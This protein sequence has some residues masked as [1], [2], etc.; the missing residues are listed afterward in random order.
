M[1]RFASC[2]KMSFLYEWVMQQKQFSKVLIA[3][4]G[5]IALRLQAACKQL[6]MQTVAVFCQEDGAA[7]FVKQADQAFRIPGSGYSAYLNMDEIIAVATKCGAQAI[8]PGYGFLSENAVFAKKVL[9]AGLVWIGPRPELITLMGDKIAARHIAAD[10][11]VPVIPGFMIADFSDTGLQLAEKQAQAIGYPLIIKDPLGGGGKGMRK[12]HAQQDFIPM[13]LQVCQQAKRLSSATVLLVEKYLTNVRHVEVQVVGDGNHAIHLFE[14]DC[15]VQR[16]YQKIIEEAPCCFVS[17]LVLERMRNLAAH[18]AQRIKYDNVG[19]IEYA[20]TD[21]E[22]FYFLEMNTRLQVEH[23]V[24]ERVTGIDIVCLQLQ[25]A[26]KKPLP[27]I[28]KDITIRGHAIECRIYAEDPENNFIPC[29]GHLS[30]FQVPH[31]PYIRVDHDLAQGGEI[32]PFF[33]PMIAKC[34]GWALTRQ[35]TCAALQAFLDNAVIEGLKTNKEFLNNL[36]QHHLF[37]EGKLYTESLSDPVFVS[38]ILTSHLCAHAHDNDY[39][40][41]TCALV[42]ALQEKTKLKNITKQTKTNCIKRRWKEQ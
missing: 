15:S 39:I 7:L 6:G 27:F 25:L 24:T 4:R 1:L 14:R 21:D 20:V 18:L 40:H 26:Q 41:A 17:Q 10:A 2:L 34:V 9:A 42:V 16:R 13:L 23:A 35:E 5:E 32:S 36:L 19:T 8:H 30:R 33:D 11:G 3:N 37:V 38:Q 31:M 12:V 28:Q 29:A 22:Q